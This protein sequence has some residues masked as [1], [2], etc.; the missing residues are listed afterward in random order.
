MAT[1]KE[2]IKESDLNASQLAEKIG[3]TKATMS[4]WIKG[5]SI[6][7]IRMCRLMS[8]ELHLPLHVIAMAFDP[9]PRGEK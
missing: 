3:V 7:N 2:L 9:T 4:H 8:K 6:P 1:F 5:K